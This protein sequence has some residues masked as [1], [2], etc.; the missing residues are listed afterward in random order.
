MYFKVSINEIRLKHLQKQSLI[1]KNINFSLSGNGIYTILGENGSGKSTLIKSITALLPENQYQ[2]D[3][4]V[5]YNDYDLLNLNESELKVIRK[6]E[7]RYVFQDP[8]NS[9]DPLKKIGY[10]FN[11]PVYNINDIEI[12][13]DYFLLPGY[14]EISEMYP[15]QIS[16]GMAQ[17]LSV[18]LAFAANPELII[19]DEPTSGIDYALMNLTYLK[20]KEYVRKKDNSVLL[21]TQEWEFASRISDYISLLSEKTMSDFLPATEFF[22]Q[23]IPSAQLLMDTYRNL[24]S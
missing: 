13:L 8:V 9:F 5:I 4:K 3:G 20:L 1:L 7:I 22:Q 6:N 2:I 23:R 17:R 10:Y 15:Y 24:K 18:I 12:L 11:S 21:V 14:K 16:G 19:L